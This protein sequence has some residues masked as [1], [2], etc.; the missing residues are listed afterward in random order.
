MHPR[1]PKRFR[2]MLGLSGAQLLKLTEENGQTPGG[3]EPLVVLTE[4]T[5]QGS[6]VCR[7]LPFLPGL[8]ALVITLGLQAAA[9]CC[10]ARLLPAAEACADL[11]A[12]S[13]KK[14]AMEITT[15]FIILPCLHALQR[16]KPL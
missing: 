16:H 4:V 6:T 14:A 13:A 15:A 8:G 9:V 11:A 3:R 10:R 1:L 2:R 5:I 12:T 7:M